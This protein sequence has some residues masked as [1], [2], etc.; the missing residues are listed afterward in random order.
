[1]LLASAGVIWRGFFFF[2]CFFSALVVPTWVQCELWCQGAKRMA[3]QNRRWWIKHRWGELR[4]TTNTETKT[5]VSVEKKKCCWWSWKMC[6][7]VQTLE[8]RPPETT[9]PSMSMLVRTNSLA[10]D[11]WGCECPT[12][13]EADS[14]SGAGEDL[15]CDTQSGS[16]K[17]DCVSVLSSS[18]APQGRVPCP[19]LFTWV[20]LWSC[21]ETGQRLRD[22]VL[23]RTGLWHVKTPPSACDGSGA[24]RRL[25]VWYFLFGPAPHAFHCD[26]ALNWY[27]CWSFIGVCVCVQQVIRMDW[28]I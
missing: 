23:V 22:L 8:A 4:K 6:W 15:G 25:R 27:W 19:L 13:P 9:L 11:L 17:W 28:I 7:W 24:S 3:D 12:N 5:K 10:D 26:V 1:M 2:S 16:W 20:N 14:E 21:R 18:G